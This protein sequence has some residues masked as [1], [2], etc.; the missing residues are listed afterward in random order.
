MAETKVRDLLDEA[1]KL[2]DIREPFEQVWEEIVDNVMPDCSGFLSDTPGQ[3]QRRGELIKDGTPQWVLT[4]YQSGM[5]GRLL[6]QYFN[7]F[8]LRVPD[9][10]MMD[11]PDVRK[12]L[13]KD[14]ESLYSLVARSNFYTAMYSY[15]GIVPI[16]TCTLY[17]YYN[18][19][20]RREVFLPQHPRCIYISR[21]ADGEVDTV[22]NARMM[23]SKAI[24][25]F[26]KADPLSEELT[27]EAADPEDR[28]CEHKILHIVKPNPKWDPRK[29]DNA[30][31]RYI[32]FYV[33]EEHESIIRRGGYRTMPYCVWAVERQ[34]DEDYGRGPGWRALADIKALYKYAETDITAAQL[35]V[36]PPR[37]IP[38]ERKGTM[39]FV[40]GARNY[41]EEAGR[42]AKLID[43]TVDLRAGLDREQR[44]QQIIERH[45]MVPF[46]TMMQQVGQDRPGNRTAYEVRR[47]E[48]ETAVLL[49]PHITGLNQ[50]VMDKIIDG[51]FDDAWNAGMI[52]PPPKQLL[53]G[54]N[55]GRLEVD[56]MGPLALAQRSYFQSEPYRKTISDLA[57]LAQMDPTGGVLRQALQNYNWD[58]MTREMSRTNGLPEEAM[59]D[60]KQRDQMREAEAQAAQR[61][62]QLAAM[63]QLGKAA[64]GLGKAPEAGSIAEQM[65]K[66]GAA[67]PA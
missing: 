17:R 9:E 34:P 60:E 43:S 37:D 5:V 49:G 61:A 51:L 11:S 8:S 25:E 36:N 3:G 54:E 55:A 10:S 15:F 46:F 14:D 23:T 63:E 41:Y 6:S 12:W 30:S 52:A 45:F 27:K 56:Y 57:G 39:K 38:L 13:S 21:S 19:Q 64:P 42:E 7:W 50:D 53:E 24:A 32:S 18:D 16:G 28:Y 47:I 58:H 67:V 66:Q 33:D 35:A 59:L 20:T 40:P 4:T 2:R 65:G 29:R 1:K 22:V 31:M 62:Q 48:E 26:F 44:K